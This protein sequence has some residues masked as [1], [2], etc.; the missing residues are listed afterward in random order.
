MDFTSYT[1]RGYLRRRDLLCPFRIIQKRDKIKVSKTERVYRSDALLPKGRRS[2]VPRKNLSGILNF[3]AS[4]RYLYFCSS[5]QLNSFNFFRII[6]YSS[7]KFD[8]KYRNQFTLKK[9]M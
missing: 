2:P 1:P 5:I 6:F 4:F 8:T 9:K 3:N 7:C